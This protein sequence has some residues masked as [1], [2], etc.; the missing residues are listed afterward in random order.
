MEDLMIEYDKKG[1]RVYEGG[2]E[3]DMMKG[4]VRRGKGTEY[5]SDGKSV[6]YVGHWRNGHRHG[7]GEELNEK[8]EV[9]RRGR[10]KDGEYGVRL[11]SGMNWEVYDND[12]IG[13]VER[14]EIRN[15]CLR[16]VNR[17]VIDG[18]NELKS[19][20][21]GRRVLDTKSTRIGSECLIM[22]C[23][24]LKEIQ[25][26][27]ASFCYYESFVCKNLPSL[28]SLR[29]GANVLKYCHSVVLESSNDD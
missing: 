12:C 19:V 17:F 24:Q 23:D 3:R 15:W 28:L 22:N 25:I 5:R 10:W 6:L 13:G 20:K 16:K 26:S 29:L 2:F 9:I 8:G 11:R 18:L 1:M 27:N 4:F 21:I 7:Y 14:V